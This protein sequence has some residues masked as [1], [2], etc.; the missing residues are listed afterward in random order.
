MG[1]VESSWLSGD[2]S[3]SQRQTTARHNKKMKNLAHRNIP[4]T[5]IGGGIHGISIALRFLREIPTTEIAI[6]DRHPLPLTAWQ[7]KTERQGMTFL[8]SPAVH[9]IAPD[10]LGIVEYAE[11]HNRGDEL[12]PPYSQPATR[13]FWDFCN[14]VLKEIAKHQDYY[15]FDVAKLR[16]D[17]GAGQYPFRLISTDTVGFRS[18]CVILAIGSD[19]CYY[20]PPEFMPWQQRWP[21]RVVH[22]S[23]FSVEPNHREGQVFHALPTE[24]EP[25]AIVGAGLTAGTLAR[26]LSE[27]GHEV[28]LI[29]RRQLKTEQFDFP[30]RWLG[31][32]AL[33]EFASEPDFQ[34]RYETVQQ[35]RGE[36]SITPDIAE[37][38]K[39]APR[40]TIYTHTCV[41]NI[42]EEPGQTLC[43][44]LESSGELSKRAYRTNVSCVIL[45]TGYQF[46]LRRYPFLAELIAQHEVP[47]VCG[48]PKL[49]ANLQ[50]L[51]VANLFG[52]GTI[53][54]LQ[55][56]PAA[57]NIAGASLAYERLREKILPQFILNRPGAEQAP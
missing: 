25:I 47:L 16:W 30:P 43:L 37:A 17:K 28:I 55:L 4:V 49:D 42:T 35:V 13:L 2:I 32:K 46:N 1:R 54:Q 40:V 33:A 10:A 41:R 50:L 45:A 48:L 6:V 56:G 18:R 14:D 29:A 19:D 8:R 53:A 34:Q 7:R 51:P 21:E 23:R 39:E 5:I 15:Q 24:K 38:L 20:V 57:G 3:P 27:R 9:H 11:C 44:H 22:A 31:P 12:A 36:G 26:S 52:T